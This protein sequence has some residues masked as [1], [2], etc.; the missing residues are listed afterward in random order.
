MSLLEPLLPAL[1]VGLFVAR[2]VGRST[3]LAPGARL[4]LAAIA[5]LAAAT[6]ALG[7]AALWLGQTGDPWNGARLAPSI[8]LHSGYALYQ[9]LETGPVL[10]TVVGPVA[11]LAYWPVG[12]LRASPTTLVLAAIALNL[13]VFALIVFALLR[14][15]TSDPSTRLFAGIVALQLSLLVP[16]LRYSLFCIHADA[17][18]LALAA[19]GILVVLSPLG[20]TWR[21]AALAAL[22]FSLATWAKQ[23][24]APIFPAVIMLVAMRDGRSAALRFVGACTI[25][26]T[27]VSATFVVWLGFDNL[28]FNMFAVPARHPWLQMNL[29]TG[30]IYP[31]LTA[32]GA[33]A[34]GK[35][36]VAAILQIVRGA[37]PLFALFAFLLGERLLRRSP[38][39]SRW[40]RTPWAAFA[41]VA[42]ALLPTA[43]TGRVKLGGEVNHE[44]FSL[45]FL[46]L[47]TVAW[48]A[49]HPVSLT[50]LCRLGAVAAVLLLVV[51]PRAAEYPGWRA[52]HENQNET[53]F[54]Y[55][56]A[57]P[58]RVYFPWNPLTSIVAEKRVY[59]F[60]Y[61]VYDRNL[62]EA[63][64]TPAHIA[65]AI[66][67]PRPV[68]ASYIAHHDHI[69]RKY[70]SDYVPLPADPE[71]PGWKLYG[72]PSASAGP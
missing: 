9:P 51:G 41:L 18:A 21:G 72:P 62:G 22:C 60:D 38:G 42:V 19:I 23:S 8:A 15:V 2:I 71:L 47:A 39:E 59:H 65:L 50:R 54:R 7:A 30:E 68:I 58:G 46:V 61:G 17:P 48:L 34:H 57:H 10:S 45:F 69:L 16:A 33:V 56:L 55:D 36:L 32:V 37:W 67:S 64:V 66:P 35:V 52:A 26:G 49:E 27:A 6:A 53:A 3:E 12:F 29:S 28:R 11:F 44:S 31:G 1:V 40:P 13:V 5:A 20:L 4:W 43:A 63:P 24:L 25:V 70:F 14:R